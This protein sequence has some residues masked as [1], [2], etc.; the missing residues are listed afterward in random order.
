MNYISHYLDELKLRKGF[1]QD[2]ELAEFLDMY[3]SDI[4][5]ARK[6]GYLTD[7]RCFKLAQEIGVPAARVIA[8]RELQKAKDGEMKQVWKHIFDAVATVAAVGLAFVILVTL[9]GFETVESAG[10]AIL[11]TSNKDYRKYL[12]AFLSKAFQP[13]VLFLFPVNAATGTA[14]S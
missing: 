9:P 6:Q 10:L 13:L 7:L 5:R 8:A 14:A 3:T 4:V 1:D 2:K 11:L 12:R